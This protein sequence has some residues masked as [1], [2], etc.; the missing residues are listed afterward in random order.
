LAIYLSADRKRLLEN[1]RKNSIFFVSP[2]LFPKEI[3][4][5]FIDFQIREVDEI[6]LILAVI[7]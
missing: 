6:N 5:Y 1:R 2:N 4:I 3:I 7:F